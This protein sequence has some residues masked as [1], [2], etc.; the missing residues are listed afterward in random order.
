MRELKIKES[1]K[2]TFLSVIVIGLITHSYM[3]LNNFL[4]ADSMWSLYADQNMITSGRWFLTIACGISSY[5][6]LP[7]VIGIL[8]L[9][10][11]GIAA[12][13]LIEIFE[14]KNKENQ[15]L[16]AGILVT[17]PALVSTYSYLY[18]A[19][20][21]MFA[22]MLVCISVYLLKKY[23]FGFIPA[24]IILGFAIGIYQAYLAFAMLLCVGLLFISILKGE[25][26]KAI[27]EKTK[28]MILYGVIG[29]VFY[30]V[31]LQILLHIQG[32]TLSTYQGID[33]MTS[34]S[35]AEFPKM[36][37]AAYRD[38]FGFALRSG[39]LA[40][41]VFSLILIISL[42]LFSLY[43]FVNQ[44][45]KIKLFYKP[46]RILLC[47]GLVLITPLATN[48]ILLI[49]SE[50]YNHLVMRYHWLLFLL[51]PIIL[52]ENFPLDKNKEIQTK[53]V[54][55]ILQIVTVLLIFNYILVANISYFNMNERYEKTYAYCI[56][57]ADRME[58]T[59]GYYPGIPVMMIGVVDEEMYPDTD[60][61]SAVT[62]SMIGVNGSIFLYTGE[63]YEAFFSHYLSI[64][65][66]VVSSEEI[67]RIYE[68]D[69]YKD[70]DPFPS[71]NS[72]KVVDGILYI[73][74]EPKE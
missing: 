45:L 20:G 29:L 37:I 39:V 55:K 17:F 49:S 48:I 21:Y 34:F 63:Q 1:W 26:A 59:D 72:M 28:H 13:F 6:Q 73:K 57:L 5:Y 71:M 68:T 58:K 43:M 30:Y 67:L 16:I 38:F 61:T 74:T 23:R 52:Y 60:I 8:S 44:G 31:M 22:V 19:D 53:Y 51:I 56:R 3:F 62:D 14:I 2:I 32:L 9:V 65:L 35:L 50:A 10:W 69:E 24:G 15:I 40:N 66:N 4:S 27:W 41:N 7:W 54:R 64:P 11:I 36:I 46:S 70:L 47:V 42:V 18:T 25:K 33:G 12:V